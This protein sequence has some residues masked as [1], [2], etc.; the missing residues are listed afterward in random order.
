MQLE[1]TILK[2]D[3]T[4]GLFIITI[5]NCNKWKG[6]GMTHEIHKL[7]KHMQEGTRGWMGRKCCGIKT[8]VYEYKGMKK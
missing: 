1:Q 5:Y 6:E 7:G 3:I 8:C 2:Y 4:L